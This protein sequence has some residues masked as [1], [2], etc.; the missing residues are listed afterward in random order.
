MPGRSPAVVVTVLHHQILQELS[1][2]PSSFAFS[3]QRSQVVLLAFER[4]SNADIAELVGLHRNQVGRWRKR[5]IQVFDH[6]VDLECAGEALSLRQAI[7]SALS[8]A[9]RSDDRFRK[10]V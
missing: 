3:Q 8:D 1:Q 5:W 10:F 7:V 4:K 9:P 2:S 6:L